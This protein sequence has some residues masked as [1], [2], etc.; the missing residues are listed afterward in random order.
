MTYSTG[1]PIQALDYNTF[2]TL[3]T[4]MNALFSDSNS[5]ATTLP[6]A[7][8]GY[9]QLPSLTSVVAGSAI[10]AAQWNAL[11][12]TMRSCGTHQGITVTPPIPATGPDIG[13]PIATVTSAAAFQTLIDTLGQNRFT[14]SLGQSSVIAGTGV[15]NPLPWLTSLIYTFQVDFG[16]WNNARYFF[17]TGGKISINGAYSPATTPDELAWRDLFIN[18]FP[19]NM[20]WQTTVSQG[21][22]SIVNPPGFY[23]SAPF[24]GLT[25][26]Y[27][28]IYRKYAS[29]GSG[30]Y[31]LTNYVLVEAKLAN[32]PGANGKIDFKISL[33]DGD[34]A[35]VSKLANRV[36]Y[37]VNRIQSGGAVPYAGGYTF[38]S[39]GFV[40]T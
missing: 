19:V 36:T 20:N 30:Y 7:G 38:F 8:F 9:G 39:G 33:I 31:Y 27:Q 29:G 25:T 2:A 3:S 16:S 21:G 6:Q 22:N 13:N 28:S 17:N 26:S 10:T 40:A 1:G 14:I 24:P 23:L 5:G 37:T 34:A 12:G 35:P 4:G 32:A 18:E 15:S 11:F